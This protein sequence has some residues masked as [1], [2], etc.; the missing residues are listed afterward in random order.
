M[1][2]LISLEFRMHKT[3]LFSMQRLQ[4]DGMFLS[5]QAILLCYFEKDDKMLWFPNRYVP[6]DGLEYTIKKR[7]I[8]N[9]I[10]SIL[11][12]LSPKSSKLRVC[13]SFKNKRNILS[14]Q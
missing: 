2:G 14:T 9:S 7:A 6:V 10:I 12:R 5:N 3:G 8:K 1:Y 11:N 4:F 13:N